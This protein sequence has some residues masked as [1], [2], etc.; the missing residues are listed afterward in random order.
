MVPGSSVI[1]R[2]ICYMVMEDEKG[3][4]EKVLAVIHNDPRYKN[5]NDINDL[6]KHTLEEISHFFE[7]YKAL[8]KEK[9]VKVG[10]WLDVKATHELINKTH[11][12]YIESQKI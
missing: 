6:N 9:W 11:N 12:K 10:S 3:M 8:E 5:I 2:P 4:D 1:V 7:T